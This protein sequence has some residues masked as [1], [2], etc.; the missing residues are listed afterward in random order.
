MIKTIFLDM[1]G[2]LVD[3]R[4]GIHGA[5]NKPYDYLTL[6][7]LW[8]FWDDWSDVT[9]EMVNAACVSEFWAELKW[10]H[11]GRDI[12][13]TIWRT[14]NSK[15]IYLLTTPMPNLESAFGKMMWVNA[16]LPEYIKRTIIT[17]AP[18]HLLARPDTLLIDDKNENIDEFIKAGGRGLLVP[19]PWNHRC[20]CADRTVE[21]VRRFLESLE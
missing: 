19:R 21:V 16:W 7:P 5:F 3:I 13:Q 18:K 1:D 11:D 12:L 9:F 17:Q 15:N 4:K 14:F 20:F 10:T 8:K 6:S 2:V